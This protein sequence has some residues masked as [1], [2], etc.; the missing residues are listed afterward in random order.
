[1]LVKC[2]LKMKTGTHSKLYPGTHAF[3]GA[4]IAQC[5]F[6][7]RLY[8]A[9]LCILVKK[10]VIGLADCLDQAMPCVVQS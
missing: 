7:T 9:L 3:N 8:L 10:K 1:M 6:Y 4:F 2:T 5:T